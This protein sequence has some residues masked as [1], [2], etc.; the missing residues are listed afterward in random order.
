M[1]AADVL[2]IM[3]GDFVPRKT[4]APPTEPEPTKRHR[5][6]RPRGEMNKTEARY[7]DELRLL[8]R[9]GQ[10]KWWKFEAVTLR[11]AR[12]TTYTPDFLVQH[13]DGSLEF[14]ETKGFWED[15]A[16]VKIKVAAEMFPMFR[17]VA[18]K[19]GKRGQWIREEFKV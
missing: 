14:I 2:K 18:L 6:S 11:L 3:K 8:E 19:P 1:D 5:T 12:K 13:L 15:D 10:I 9:A 4:A 17:F 16:R 7:A